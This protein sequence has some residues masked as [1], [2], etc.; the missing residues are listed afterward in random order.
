MLIKAQLLARIATGEVTLAFRRW[1]R[2]TVHAGGRLRTGVGVLA[3]ESVEQISADRITQS[4]ARR[5]GFTSAPEL[6]SELNERTVGD[7]YRIE[8]SYAG[9]DPRAALRENTDL[10]D[11]DRLAIEERLTRFDASGPWTRAALAALHACGELHAASLAER[12]GIAKD[13]L[14]V[15]MRNLKELGLTDSHRSGYRLSRRG[16][17]FLNLQPAR[18][19]G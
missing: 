14:K 13:D 2:P 11:S 18:R 4:E 8:L 10:D 16:A 5:A 6:L 15:R 3:I 12:L 17:A 19:S 7:I 1:R 9:A